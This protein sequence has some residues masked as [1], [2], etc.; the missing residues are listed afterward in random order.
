MGACGPQAGFITVKTAET[1]GTVEIPGLPMPRE[2]REWAR[3][4]TGITGCCVLVAARMYRTNP[5]GITWR[6]KQ[7]LTRALAVRARE[8]EAPAVAPGLPVVPLELAQRVT[9]HRT[10]EAPGVGPR[11]AVDLQGVAGTRCPV[12]GLTSPFR[13]G[14]SEACGRGLTPQPR[15]APSQPAW[16]P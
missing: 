13:T 3:S 5:E 14:F 7:V 9:E 12:E 16:G 2:E 11:D 10:V 15:R 6:V 1:V 8:R 4:A